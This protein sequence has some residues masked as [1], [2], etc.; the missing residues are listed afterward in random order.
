MSIVVDEFIG[1]SSL[2]RPHRTTRTNHPDPGG[3]PIG[4]RTRTST[5][6]ADMSTMAHPRISRHPEVMGGQPCITGTR[7][8]VAAL[9]GQLAAGRDQRQ[10]LAD[11]PTLTHLDLSAALSFAARSISARADH[12]STAR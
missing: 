6:A 3:I 8:P 5:V 7:I 9:L 1:F 10:I 12:P 4:N 11:Y 2:A